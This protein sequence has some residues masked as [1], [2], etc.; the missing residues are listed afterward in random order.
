MKVPAYV[1]IPAETR[2][3]VRTI[4]AIDSR[5]SSKNRCVWTATRQSP[6][7][8]SSMVG[9]RS[10]KSPRPRRWR[11][12]SSD[13]RGRRVRNN[14]QGRPSEGAV[15]D[16][17]RVHPAAGCID[18]D[19]PGVVLAQYERNPVIMRRQHW[20]SGH[21]KIRLLSHKLIESALSSRR[22]K[23]S[24]IST[25]TRPQRMAHRSEKSFGGPIIRCA[26]RNRA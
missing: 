8:P 14:H 2:V 10:R 6:G 12:R 20:F 17:D 4:D 25:S 19:P 18:T 3:S 11:Q 1:T 15:R 23:S 7:M 22:T 21:V 26:L 24:S 16:P 9:W 5:P 13:R